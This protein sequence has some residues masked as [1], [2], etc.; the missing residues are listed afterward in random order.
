[1]SHPLSFRSWQVVREIASGHYASI[2]RGRSSV[3]GEE[4]VLKITNVGKFRDRVNLWKSAL[5]VDSEA[6]LLRRCLHP[7]ILP[8]RESFLEADIFILVCEYYAGGDL[9]AHVLRYGPLESEVAC[10][11]GAYVCRGLLYLDQEQIAHRDIKPDNILLSGSDVLH[12][13]AVIADFGFAKVCP[14]S[15]ACTTFLGTPGYMAPEIFL[16]RS[17]QRCGYGR[18]VDVWALGV[19]LYVVLSSTTP[20][21]SSDPFACVTSCF[22]PFDDEVWCTISSSFQRIIGGLMVPDVSLRLEYRAVLS[23]L[24]EG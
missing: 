3:G 16:T 8:Y 7:C 22:I 9:C 2:W 11:I 10:S 23:F 17:R 1:M 4:A 19:L 6:L 20:F 12:A 21:S 14:S 18:S 15:L 13:V 24:A 5:Q